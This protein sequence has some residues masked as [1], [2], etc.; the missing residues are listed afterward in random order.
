MVDYSLFK[1]LDIRVGTIISASN[2]PEARNPSYKLTIDFGRS[3]ILKSSAQ[4][5]KL[6]IPQ[7]LINKQI[8]AVINLGSIKIANYES[9]CLILGAVDEENVFLLKP[10]EKTLNGEI[11]F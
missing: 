5:T 4:I 8:I 6:Y 7:N 2:F 10:K 11:V 3:G 1:N 9:Q